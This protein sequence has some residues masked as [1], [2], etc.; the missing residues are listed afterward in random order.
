[1][2]PQNRLWSSPEPLAAPL[3]E[4]SGP[5]VPAPRA[6]TEGG[7]PPVTVWRTAAGWRVHTGTADENFD[8]LGDAMVLADLLAPDPGVERAPR[9]TESG[10]SQVEQLRKTVAQLEYALRNRIVVERAIGVIAERFQ[11]SPNDAF[12]KLRRVARSQR[13]RVRELAGDVLASA[14]DDD[15]E[16]PDELD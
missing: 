15:V 16:L 8:N 11:L 3:A 7:P 13:L 1:M 5:E 4:Q 12:A 14:L 9:R 6:S 2:Q 10:G